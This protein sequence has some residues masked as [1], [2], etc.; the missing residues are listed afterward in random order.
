[1]EHL[2]L[3]LGFHRSVKFDGGEDRFLGFKELPRELFEWPFHESPVWSEGNILECPVKYSLN[4]TEG[5][6]SLEA[7]LI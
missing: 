5:Q 1:M 3:Q 7:P 4:E 6:E 2:G